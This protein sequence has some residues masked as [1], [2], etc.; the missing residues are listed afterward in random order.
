MLNSQDV[1]ETIRCCR[2][3]LCIECPL[4]KEI[5]DTLFVEMEELPTQLV[6]MIEELFGNGSKLQ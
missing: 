6:D 2:E 5:C 1:L 4:Q 3:G